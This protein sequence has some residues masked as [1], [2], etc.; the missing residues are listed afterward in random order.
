METLVYLLIFVVL[1][2]TVYGRHVATRNSQLL[3]G[4]DRPRTWAEAT[5]VGLVIAL[6]LLITAEVFLRWGARITPTDA[7]W[8]LVPAVLWSVGMLIARRHPL[9]RTSVGT[10]LATLLPHVYQTILADFQLLSVT[11]AALLVGATFFVAARRESD[12]QP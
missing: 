2:T 7:L 1:A 11:A 5:V 9:D 3:E 4:D 6:C 8:N 12:T 10:G